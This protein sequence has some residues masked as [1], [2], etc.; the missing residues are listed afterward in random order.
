MTVPEKLDAF[1]KQL[2][3]IAKGLLM[4]SLGLLGMAYF[5]PK[6]CSNDTQPKTSMSEAS[7]PSQSPV[8]PSQ[9]PAIETSAGLLWRDYQRNEVSADSKYKGKILSV[10]GKLVAIK[11]N[12]SDDAYLVLETPN[13]FETVLAN[14]Q[15]SE[16][17][18][19]STLVPGT[20][21][22]V[23]CKGGGMTLG[24]PML[25]DCAIQ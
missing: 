10:R 4:L 2:A 5:W 7:Q 6:S 9:A 8:A 15:K 3:E 19:A 17:P 21:V 14:L 12:F 25:N 20:I 22:T 11:K 16:L 1:S 23:I 24:S 13:E 18:N